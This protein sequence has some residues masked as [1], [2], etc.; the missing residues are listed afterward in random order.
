M[1]AARCC[2]GHSGK[3]SLRHMTSEVALK[4]WIGV[5]GRKQEKD[6]PHKGVDGQESKICRENGKVWCYNVRALGS[7]RR[8]W[9]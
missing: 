8:W 1:W 3:A 5:P 9:R 6:T 4:G 2:L 7:G